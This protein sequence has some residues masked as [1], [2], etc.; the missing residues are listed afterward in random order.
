MF[1]SS[2]V[3]VCVCVCVCVLKDRIFLNSY[4]G[5]WTNICTDPVSW[6]IAHFFILPK[7]SLDENLFSLPPSLSPSFP[8]SLPSSIHSFY[9]S[10]FLPF[11]RQ[12]FSHVALAV[13]DLDLYTRL[14]LNSQRFT[15]L[16]LGSKVCATISG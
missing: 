7:L 14:A 9:L 15:C 11:M 12:F 5:S 4:S 16:C 1:K 2:T 3:C 13:L 8:L 6:A 10:Y